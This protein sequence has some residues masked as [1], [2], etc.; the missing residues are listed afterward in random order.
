[1]ML[2]SVLLLLFLKCLSLP[3]DSYQGVASSWKSSLQLVA[4]S[5]PLFLLS[6]FLHCITLLTDLSLSL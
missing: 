6:V 4:P 5:F 1:M 3:E 2:F